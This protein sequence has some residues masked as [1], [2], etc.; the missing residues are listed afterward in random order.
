MLA[1]E[2]AL[3]ARHGDT[4]WAKLV[5][6][7]R[8]IDDG[9]GAGGTAPAGRRDRLVRARP[10]PRAAGDRRVPAR[11]RPRPQHVP[12]ALAGDLRGMPAGRGPCRA[13]DP[14]L[15]ARLPL[16][17]PVPGRPRMPGLRRTRARCRRSSTPATAD[18]AP[19]RPPSRRCSR[20]TGCAGRGRRRWMPSSC[21]PRGRPTSSSGA[22][23][24]GTAS[25]SGL[26]SFAIDDQRVGPGRGLRVRRSTDAREG[27]RRPARRVGARS[28]TWNSGSRARDHSGRTSPPA[29]RRRRIVPLGL[30]RSE[31]GASASCSGHERSCS[32][33]ERT[34]WRPLTVVE[35]YAAGVPVIAPAFGVVP[36]MVTTA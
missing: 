4:A 33:P 5:V 12:A 26:T 9:R 10:P 23:Y 34:R 30:R 19:P 15:P 20:S 17:D 24:R 21:T 1:A 14:Q 36:S 6:D 32:P 22:A 25:T 11:R 35:A 31:R 29:P 18:R 2:S 27:R 7:N 13:D 16:V 8:E 3:L 28:R